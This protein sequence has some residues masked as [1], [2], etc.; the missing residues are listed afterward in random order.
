[1]VYWFDNLHYKKYND[2]K[3]LRRMIMKVENEF[4]KKRKIWSVDVDG[5]NIKVVNKKYIRLYVNGELQDVFWG[6]FVNSS[7]LRGKMPDGREVKV[8]FGGRFVFQLAIFVDSQLV[9]STHKTV[10]KNAE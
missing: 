8:R 9:L 10:T 6:L 7:G 5:I 3:S 4:V 1:L 2:K